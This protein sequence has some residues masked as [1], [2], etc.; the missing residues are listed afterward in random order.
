MR[1]GVEG[2][3]KGQTSRGRVAQL[4]RELMRHKVEGGHAG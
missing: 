4:V 2:V 3:I 1:S